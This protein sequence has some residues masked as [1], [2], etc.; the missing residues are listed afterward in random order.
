MRRAGAVVLDV[1]PDGAAEA[2]VTQ[3]HFLK[4]RGVL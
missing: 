1:P 3:Y 4:R 2:V